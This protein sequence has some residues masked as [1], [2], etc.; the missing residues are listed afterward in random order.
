MTCDK[1]SLVLRQAFFA[2]PYARAS[3]ASLMHDV[4]DLDV[5]QRD[6][7]C[8]VDPTCRPFAF[9]DAAGVCAAS[10]EIFTLSLILDSVRCAASGIRSVAVSEAWRGRGLFRD[11]MTQALAWCDATLAGPVLL[12]TEDS[13]LYERFGF[14]DVPQHKVVG[15]ASVAS[16]TIPVRRVSLTDANDMTLVM[17]LLAERAPVSEHIAVD[18]AAMLFLSQIAA[19]DTLALDYAVSLDTLIVSKP[20]ATLTTLVDIAAPKIPPL[21]AILAALHRPHGEVEILFPPDKLGW[22]GALQRDDTGLMLRGPWP[23]AFDRPFMLPP[24]AEF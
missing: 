12:Y 14:R 21:T 6:A 22:T 18:G 20:A 1:A 17:R 5:E 19:D 7:L 24:T 15:T 9:F 8:G 2:D 16:A 23:A 13:A 4:F 11:L 10:V 3:Y